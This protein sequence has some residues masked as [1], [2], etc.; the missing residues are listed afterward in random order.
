M[1]GLNLDQALSPT[2]LLLSSRLESR[3]ANRQKSWLVQH[4]QID[5][6]RVQLIQPSF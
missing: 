4:E 6:A 5:P 2:I 1:A 3:C